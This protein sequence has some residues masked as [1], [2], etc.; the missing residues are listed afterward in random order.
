[1]LMHDDTPK[2]AIRSHIRKA[3]GTTKKKEHLDMKIA[4]RALGKA[5]SLRVKLGPNNRRRR[6]EGELD[7]TEQ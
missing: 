2:L 7:K 4:G 6:R 5:I 1:M 3:R